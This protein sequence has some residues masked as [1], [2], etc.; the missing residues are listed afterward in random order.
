MRVQRVNDLP[1]ETGWFIRS[2]A[3]RVSRRSLASA[4]RK[5]R[6]RPGYRRLRQSRACRHS[7]ARRT[8][9]SRAFNLILGIPSA[10]PRRR[11]T[12]A[13][14][15]NGR[16]R[17]RVAQ[18][19]KGAVGTARAAAYLVEVRLQKPLILIDRTQAEPRGERFHS[20]WQGRV[21][22]TARHYLSVW[23]VRAV[24]TRGLHHARTNYY[25]AQTD[26]TREASSARHGAALFLSRSF[27]HGGV[28]TSA[29]KRRRT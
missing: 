27:T 6:G 7:C 23:K 12:L 16:P 19:E 18:G 17:R 25:Q 3:R 2:V 24:G 1:L 21:T 13:L 9:R 8:R 28:F 22:H 4:F 10:R 20:C 14:T 15:R 5:R 26:A 29:D 11:N